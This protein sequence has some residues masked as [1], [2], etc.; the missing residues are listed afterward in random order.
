MQGHFCAFTLP[1]TGGA[2]S[3]RPSCGCTTPGPFITVTIHPSRRSSQIKS[4]RRWF[5]SS[6]KALASSRWSLSQHLGSEYW[7]P[8]RLYALQVLRH[9][10]FQASSGAAAPNLMA[11]K[12]QAANIQGTTAIQPQRGFCMTT[13]TSYIKSLALQYSSVDSG[14]QSAASR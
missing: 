3:R 8:K 14:C 1:F 2:K 9:R 11:N 4:K 10:N 6:R 13:G 7:C 12:L 5:D